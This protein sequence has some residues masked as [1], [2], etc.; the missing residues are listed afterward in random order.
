[1]KK[2]LSI[3]VVMMVVMA[4]IFAATGDKLWI[5]SSVAAVAPAFSMYG[6]LDD[7]D[8][9]DLTNLGEGAKTAG[10]SNVTA[11]TLAAGSI[12]DNDI[13]VYLAVV[14]NNDAQWLNTSGFTLTVTATALTGSNGGSVTPSIADSDGG[15]STTHFESTVQSATG[16]V[17]TYLVKYKTGTQ[18]D[19]GALVGTC[20]FNYEANS[21]LPFG[22]YSATITLAYT[23]S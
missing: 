17:V 18:V 11:T 14:Q 19:A 5:T 6:S 2:V 3:L 8:L 21:S 12:K 10:Q 20:Q 15:E 4:S 1:M 7:A 16:L 9:A 13:D 22:D 23:A